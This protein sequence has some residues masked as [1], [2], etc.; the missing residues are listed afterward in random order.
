M[1]IARG[2]QQAILIGDQCQLPPTAPCSTIWGSTAC[3]RTKSSFAHACIDS[4]DTK[5]MYEDASQHACIIVRHVYVHTCVY[6]SVHTGS[7][8]SVGLQNFRIH[9]APRALPGL[10]G[11]VPFSFVL[12]RHASFVYLLDFLRCGGRDGTD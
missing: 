9:S 12:S 7:L 6:A 4:K 5:N 2:C 11:S 3:V 10:Q 1:P 8:V